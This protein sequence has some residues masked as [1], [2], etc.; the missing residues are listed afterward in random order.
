M[1]R[2]ELVTNAGEARKKLGDLIGMDMQSFE[3]LE[4]FAT[5]SEE[6][7]QRNYKLSIALYCGAANAIESAVQAYL[8]KFPER[9]EREARC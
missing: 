1:A 2:N 3:Q 8:T 6:D 5:V 9:N 7:L 4:R